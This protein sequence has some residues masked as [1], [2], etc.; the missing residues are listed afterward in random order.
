MGLSWT[1]RCEYEESMRG[2]SLWIETLVFCAGRT[3]LLIPDKVGVVVS[4]V[5]LQS[6]KII[7]MRQIPPKP[8]AWT[9]GTENNSH[10]KKLILALNG[11]YSRTCLSAGNKPYLPCASQGKSVRT[12]HY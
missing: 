3:P 11:M 8:F 1:L 12:N 6:E 9:A 2:I 5:Y 10:F 7:L 4:L